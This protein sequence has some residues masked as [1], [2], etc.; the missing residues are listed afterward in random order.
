MEF[1]EIILTKDLS[2][3]TGAFLKKTRLFLCFKNTYKKSAKQDKNSSL[4]PETST[5]NAVY[6][7][8]LWFFCDRAGVCR[9]EEEAVVLQL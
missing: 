3:S 6:E 2:L 4:C 5:K 8:H 1:L 9:D 7:F